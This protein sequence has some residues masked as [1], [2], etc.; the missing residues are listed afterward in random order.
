[1]EI[2][3]LAETYDIVRV[4]GDPYDPAYHMKQTL[5]STCPRCKTTVE[6]LGNKGERHFTP[7]KT[8]LCADCVALC[9]I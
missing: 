8:V 3:V 2:V 1:M 7:H 5:S 6:Y 4:I 9:Q